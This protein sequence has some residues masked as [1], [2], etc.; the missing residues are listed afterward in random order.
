PWIRSAASA[1]MERLRPGQVFVADPRERAAAARVFD[2]HP[3]ERRIEVVAAVEEPG[4][5]VDLIAKSDGRSLVPRPDR[6]GEPIA[7]VVHEPH[8]M[9]VVVYRQD[10]HHGTEHF[11]L[12]DLHV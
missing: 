6:R 4:A 11:L 3:G 2:A 8:G 7:A 1:Q 12:H 10:A 5:G 9:S